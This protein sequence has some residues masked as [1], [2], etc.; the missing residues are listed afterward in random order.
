MYTNER[1]A[2]PITSPIPKPCVTDCGF[3]GEVLLATCVTPKLEDHTLS[4]V[5]D[6]L[7]NTFATTLH[8]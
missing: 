3:H 2:N 8:I 7:F 4:A 5:G 1:T 6:I